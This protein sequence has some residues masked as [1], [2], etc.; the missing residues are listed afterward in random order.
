MK[1]P[2]LI[3][4][5]DGSGIMA[6]FYRSYSSFLRGKFNRDVYK[7]SIST[8]ATCPN[9]DGTLG[10]GGCAYCSGSGSGRVSDKS[11]FEQ[12]KDYLLA[13][14]EGRTGYIAYFQSYSNMYKGGGGIIEEITRMLSL[15]DIVG[16]SIATRPDAL[17]DDILFF[18][19]DIS[20][21]KFVQI[22]LGMETANDITL[23]AINRK[24]KSADFLS[25]SAKVKCEIPDSHLV[26]HIIIGLPEE[27][28]E[29]FKKTLSMFNESRSDGIK[30]HHLYVIKNTKLE[31]DF[32]RGNI[33][34]MSEEEYI[35]ILL[36]LLSLVPQ[37]KVI[38]RL[39]S[40]SDAFELVA[41][42]WTLDRRF[43]EKLRSSA[44]KN[45]IYQGS[46]YGDNYFN[47]WKKTI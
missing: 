29:D 43:H 6:D 45:K 3:S 13:K 31:A 19:K 10:T 24:M 16:F 11:P 20:K 41:P 37:D 17:D 32:K 28:E 9:R 1:N 15:D 46:S 35:D 27:D 22:E 36:N 21:K 4:C 47:C 33:E 2:N 34:T 42:L 30:F 23:E 18:L 14:K 38:H 40:T 8:K 26:C 44:E 12:V 7:I 5:H 25:A 39:K